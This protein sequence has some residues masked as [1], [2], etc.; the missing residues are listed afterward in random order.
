MPKGAFEG[1][2]TGTAADA[3]INNAFPAGSQT[4]GG[5]FNIPTNSLPSPMFLAGSFEQQG[6]DGSYLEGANI[7]VKP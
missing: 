3:G 4:G 7:K 6:S 5:G 2:P 1:G